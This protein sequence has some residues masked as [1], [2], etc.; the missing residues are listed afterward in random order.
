MVSLTPAT[1]S[2]CWPSCGI[3]SCSGLSTEV[4]FSSL[5]DFVFLVY[6]MDAGTT[7]NILCKKSMEL[8]YPFGCYMPICILQVKQSSVTSVAYFLYV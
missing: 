1:L 7:A 2:A 3:A 6:M 4:L 8:I 5:L